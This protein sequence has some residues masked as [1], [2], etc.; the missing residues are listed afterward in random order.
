MHKPEDKGDLFALIT[1]LQEALKSTA[2][3]NPYE[4]IEECPV[5]DRYHKSSHR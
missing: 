4:D 3:S 5:P 2:Y 1:A